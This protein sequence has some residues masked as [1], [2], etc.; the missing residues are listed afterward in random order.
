[1]DKTHKITIP[2]PCHENWNKM[3]PNENGRFCLSC[4]KTVV[5]FTSMLPN[6]VQHYF[7]QNENIKI[8]GRFKNTQLESIT[9]QIPDRVLYSQTNYS[10]MFLLALFV[11]MGTTLFSCADN[12]GN[13][14]KIDKIEIVNNIEQDENEDV[15]SC[16]G[17]QI[18]SKKEKKKKDLLNPGFTTGNIIIS[19]SIQT[20]SFNYHTIYNSTDLDVLPVPEIGMEKFYAF[21]AKNFKAP[22]NMKKFYGKAFIVF[23]VEE[24]GSLSNFNIEKN[25]SIEI[26]K[27]AIKILK[28]APNWSPGKLKKRIV[29]SSFT[30]EI[31]L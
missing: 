20:G 30:F 27:E 24:D 7:I 26:G 15:S 19:N 14:N 9:I 12:N 4:A 6:E 16:Y 29:R 31:P 8:C 17:H 5:D 21:F 18:E 28:T 13:K 10:K 1:M 2:K 3:T 11:S 23:V 25:T 22:K